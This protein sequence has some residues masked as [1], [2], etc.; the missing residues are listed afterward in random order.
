MSIRVRLLLLI[1][2]ALSLLLGYQIMSNPATLVFCIIGGLALAWAAHLRS[3]GILRTAVLIFG[4]IATVVSVFVNPTAWWM[5]F[6]AAVAAL[7]VGNR[8][9]STGGLLPWIRKQF[10]SVRTTEEVQHHDSRHAWFGDQVFGQ[11]VFEWKDINVT[12]LTGDTIVDLGNTLLPKR[13]NVVMIRKGF[14]KTRLLVPIGVG[15][16]LNHSALVGQVNFAG[17]H[18]D[19]RNETVRLFSDDY[20]VAP[21][22]LR[23]VTSAL[24]GD[25][26]VVPV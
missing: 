18:A 15:I 21:R 3:R 20:D 10:V 9:L 2:V 13:D 11:S 1:E 5:V 7:F 6:I 23:I 16:E 17:R 4:G 22:R 26:E 19:L 24:I 12:L 14:G 8:S 25:L